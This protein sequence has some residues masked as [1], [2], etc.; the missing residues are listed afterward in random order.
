MTNYLAGL[1]VEL[2]MA[3]CELVHEAGEGPYLA[4]ISRAFVPVGR[5]LAFRK[6]EVKKRAHLEQLCRVVEA[7]PFIGTCIV[8]LT[9]LTPDEESAVSAPARAELQAFFRRLVKVQV[10]DIDRASMA[11]AVVLE[12]ALDHIPVLPRLA[13]LTLRAAANA[14]T[15]IF[16]PSSYVNLNQYS[17][18]RQLHL[19][20]IG[21][22]LSRQS[23]PPPV[24]PLCDQISHLGLYG[25]LSAVDA[26]ASLSTLLDAVQA[27]ALVRSLA[28]MQQGAGRRLDADSLKC[29]VNLVVFKIG[30]RELISSQDLLVHLTHVFIDPLR[31]VNE[32]DLTDNSLLPVLDVVK[33]AVDAHEIGVMVCGPY[34]TQAIQ[35]YSRLQP[36]VEQ[37]EQEEEPVVAEEDAEVGAAPED[38][39]TS[40]SGAGED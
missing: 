27:P 16:T 5:R 29:L 7:C 30:F 14:P 37:V 36:K 17:Q 26:P 23:S 25:N 32:D 18:L 12:A 13:E 21:P 11:I 22:S 10:L 40:A 33:L 2:F 39:G 34:V 38:A 6:V 20:T 9:L 35:A 15:S 31:D 28:L 24:Q 8:D 1:P 3:I 4:R 19:Y